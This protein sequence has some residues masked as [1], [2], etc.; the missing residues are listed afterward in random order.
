KRTSRPMRNNIITTPNSAKCMISV[1]SPTKMLP[2]WRQ[3]DA[4]RFHWV[5][6]SELVDDQLHEG[7]PSDRGLFLQ[8]IPCPLGSRCR[9][10]AQVEYAQR[11]AVRPEGFVIGFSLGFDENYCAAAIWMDFYDFLLCMVGLLHMKLLKRGP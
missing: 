8:E 2:F 9:F 1:R 6:Y 3:G 7:Q 5:L 4:G 11:Q 10:V